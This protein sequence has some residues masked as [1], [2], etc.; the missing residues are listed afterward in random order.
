MEDDGRS[1]AWRLLAR[2]YALVAAEFNGDFEADQILREDLTPADEEHLPEAAVAVAA[3][4]VTRTSRDD[5]SWGPRFAALPDG[6]R[7]AVSDIVRGGRPGEV[8]LGYGDDPV[9]VAVTTVTAYWLW[10]SDEDYPRARELAQE[11][12]L[13]MAMIAG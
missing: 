5:P 3:S 7:E 13:K 9:Q 1:Y 2:L 6:V 11:H 8:H 12:C 4:I 10:G